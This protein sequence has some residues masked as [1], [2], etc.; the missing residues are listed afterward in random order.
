ME[1]A[2]EFMRRRLAAVLASCVVLLGAC[3]GSGGGGSGGGESSSGGGESARAAAESPPAQTTNASCYRQSDL[4]PSTWERLDWEEQ[5]CFAEDSCNGGLGRS[6]IG[7]LKWATGPDEPAL[8]WSAEVTAADTP[9]GRPLPTDEGLPLEHGLFATHTIC[10]ENSE[11]QVVRW[12]ANARVPIYAEPNPTSRRVGRLDPDEIVVLVE[13]ARFVAA[14]RGVAVEAYN[15]MNV[16]DIVYAVADVCKWHTVWRRGDLIEGIDGGVAWEPRQRL[17]NPSN[18]MWVRFERANGQSG[19]ARESVLWG[20][21][22]QV[23]PPPP[24][25][26]PPVTEAGEEYDECE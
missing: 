2:E 26:P 7:C 16:G 9:A 25:P 14:R 20:H 8:P 10:G 23:D 13:R 22:A 19:W 21:L 4:D 24:P 17:Y 5:S 15:G 18:G 3:G 1:A 11:C 12:R 6:Y